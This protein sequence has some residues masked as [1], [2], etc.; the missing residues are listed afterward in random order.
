MLKFLFRKNFKVNIK[1]IAIVLVILMLIQ[2]LI[3]IFISSN[4]RMERFNETAAKAFTASAVTTSEMIESIKEVVL[5]TALERDVNYMMLAE[6]I[7]N[8]AI[9]SFRRTVDAVRD[10]TFMNIDAFYVYNDKT[11]TLYDRSLN[12]IHIDVLPDTK[13][14]MEII[15]DGAVGYKIS[16]FVD[17]KNFT[18]DSKAS[19]KQKQ[20]LRFRYFPSLKSKSCLIMDVNISQLEDVF[21]DYAKEFSSQII[22]MD[23]KG[24]LI[25]SSDSELIKY[26]E[27]DIEYINSADFSSAVQRKYGEEKYLVIRHH[28]KKTGLNMLSLIPDSAIMVDFSETK[29][30]L[31]INLSLVIALFVVLMFIL[32]VRWIHKMIG[33]NTRRQQL[34]EE[35]GRHNKLMRK[36]QHLVNCLFKPDEQDIYRTMEYISG[37]LEGSGVTVDAESRMSVFRLE[38][39]SY[40]RFTETHSNRDV[41]LYK[42]G[43]ANICEEIINKHVRAIA[44]YEQDAEITYLLLSPDIDV[45]R[46]AFAECQ[47][48]VNDYVG[49]KISAMLSSEGNLRDLP[50]LYAET[51]HMAEY[52]FILEESIFFE[53]G[54][55]KNLVSVGDKEL[56]ERLD[57]VCTALSDGGREELEKFYEWLK[58]LYIADAKNVM[59]ILMF[60]LSSIGKSNVRNIGSMGELA[61]RFNSINS[62]TEM[63][64]F[65]ECLIEQV[66]ANE[67]D[68]G[69]TEQNDRIKTVR[70]IIDNQFRNPSF[71]SADVAE[72]MGLS[73]AYLSQKYKQATG[74][75]ISEEING[76]RM[77]AFASEL[78]TTN[79]NVKTIIKD[80]G[81]VNHN[82][83]MMMFKKK[84]GMTPT[85]YRQEFK[86][87]LETE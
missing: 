49:L 68:A 12:R 19:V 41:R 21:K 15:N 87:H 50:T 76:R 82:Y 42:Y 8:D 6:T 17:K 23:S 9:R 53:P 46:N 31:Y 79:K 27:N 66:F 77:E 80:V 71:C 26:I 3:I 83:F 13:T 69:Q 78:L 70:R 16:M 22:M 36:K 40:D 32:I 43:I 52:K 60:K 7:T 74:K 73:K 85:E 72:E 58:H 25:Y 57:S 75:S 56:N 45:C 29:T 67:N 47:A 14:K 35:T 1:L 33:E 64:K 28:P 54:M 59:W 81:G 34:D 84:Y 61:I 10:R 4:R 65:F 38:I 37:L 5:S 24:E 62:L 48:A 11:Q 55:L 63:K 86:L 18:I 44:A 2:M 51:Q 39:D 30:L 20:T